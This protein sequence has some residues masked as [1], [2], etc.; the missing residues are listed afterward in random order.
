MQDRNGTYYA[1]FRSSGRLIQKR[2]SKDF[3]VA[4]QLLREMQAKSDRGEHVTPSAMALTDLTNQWLKYCD[5]TIAAST[6]KRYRE[7]LANILPRLSCR[8]VKQLTPDVIVDYRADRLEDVLFASGDN[9][10]P[11]SN[12]TINME[13][14]A[15][16]TSLNWAASAEGGRII[17]A[18]PVVAVKPLPKKPTKERRALTVDEILLIFDAA[19]D[20]LRPALQL[21][22]QTGIRRTELV[23]LLFDDVDLQR[24]LITIRAENTKSKKQREI[25]IDD[26]MAETIADLQHDAPFRAP[27]P[28][29]REGRLSK[30]HV[31]VGEAN[32]PYS[33]NL[34]RAFY[35]VC[36]RVGIED[37]Y[38]GGSIDI[39]A[40]RGTYVTVAL[41]H[42]ANPKAVQ[43]TVG[44]STL[45]MTMNVYAKT[46]D[47]SKREA[48]AVLPYTSSSTPDVLSLEAARTG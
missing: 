31:F 35:A 48:L 26:A 25:P 14:G 42:G 6:V 44:H 9:A 37:A 23:S 41:D 15:L 47:R 12:R 34:L 43:A 22:L 8:T 10:R 19:P 33:N 1:K 46:S 17:H 40:L 27:T 11:V 16:S 29:T 2:L 5:Q 28:R 24:K 39:H 13:V 32:T 45:N 38:P 36:R 21:Y 3:R 30:E 4:C 18:N 7:N 20:Y